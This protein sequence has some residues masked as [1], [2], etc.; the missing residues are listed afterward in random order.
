M[1]YPVKF[2]TSGHRGIIG[3]SF[4]HAHVSAI[5]KAIAVLLIKTNPH[6]KVI[7]GYDPRE[8]N[9]PLAL[10]NTFTQTC[11]ATLHA[12][13][14]TPIFLPNYTP[15]PV[16]SWAITHYHLDGG[17]I[18]TASHNPPEYNG[19]KFN[20]Q[21]GAP[22]DTETT[23]AIEKLANEFLNTS[24]PAHPHYTPSP[25][26]NIPLT[27]ATELHKT[28][29]Q[30]ITPNHPITFPIVIDAKH[31]AVG[32]FW[33]V[34]LSQVTSSPFKIIHKAPDSQFKN[35]IPNPTKVES[36]GP[37]KK[38]Q[39]LLQAPIAIANDPDGDRHVILDETG[40]PLSPEET[41][42]IIAD[43]FMSKKIPLSEIITTV[44]SSRLIKKFCI[45]HSLNYSETPV[46]FKYIATYLNSAKSTKKI[47]FGVESSGG[48]SASFHTMEKCGFL[49]ALL[50]IYILA[51]TQ[52]SLS[53]LKSKLKSDFG[54]DYF[55]EVE[56]PFNATQQQRIQALLKTSTLTDLRLKTSLSIEK[57]DTQD[58]LKLSLP[59]DDWVLIRLSG[60]EPIA[61]IYAESASLETANHLIATA[62]LLLS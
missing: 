6:P 41:T 1:H 32:D 31:G 26:E 50:I 24:S 54:Q 38:A 16:V 10:H 39:A 59:N 51:D 56:H 30:L 43:Y 47:A 5:C 49:P 27:F 9:N 37:L 58:G 46:G 29:T 42:V 44:A 13:G 22:A 62:K 18:L 7:I 48:F 11:I 17:I 36:L 4:T 40:T 61:R 12:N 15:T 55:V 19:L 33:E 60:T 21:K 35:I 25:T 23:S 3:K 52:K 34:I 20:T 28:L 14:V 8:G 2:G 57:I 53:Q 45:Q